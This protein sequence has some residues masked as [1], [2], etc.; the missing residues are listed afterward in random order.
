MQE[1]KYIKSI[2]DNV[3]VKTDSKY[4]V[5]ECEEGDNVVVTITPSL[6]KPYISWKEKHRKDGEYQ[7]EET[8]LTTV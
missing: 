2:F 4:E 5:C 6:L 7:A 8:K 3:V 1:T